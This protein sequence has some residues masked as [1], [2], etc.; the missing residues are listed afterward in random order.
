MQTVAAR[1]GI[2]GVGLGKV[3][4][5]HRIPVPGRGYWQQVRAGHRRKQK[6]LPPLNG[7][8]KADTVV[9]TPRTPSARRTQESALPVMQVE[10]SQELVAPHREVEKALRSLRGARKGE[11]GVLVPRA[12]RRLDI[13]VTAGCL[14][15]A[16][17]IM[18]AV[19]KAAETLGHRVAIT[20]EPPQ[21]ACLQ[22]NGEEI[23]F[24]LQE[25]LER[26]A[27]RSTPDDRF[28]AIAQ[29]WF[30]PPK[31]DYVPTGR[32]QL[33]IESSDGGR[34]RWSDGKRR[35]LEDHLGHFLRGLTLAAEARV[36]GRARAA[37]YEQRRREETERRIE[38]DRRRWEEKRREEALLRQ[39]RDWITAR[40]VRLYLIELRKAARVMVP[41]NLGVDSA[42]SWISWA[43][44][45]AQRLDPV[46][47]ARR[48]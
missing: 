18:D 33:K 25:Q 5:R 30:Q 44:S 26:V 2:S 29:S 46:S 6:E 22:V 36:A 42:E 28:K 3:C 40:D 20:A 24:S 1:Y 35:T 21:R 19:L 17:R 41:S 27:H 13:R 14:D 38:A 12:A 32:L 34:N 11:W 15:R 43:A 45:Y 4:R 9:L 10:V 16:L 31:F 23:R 47:Q 39:V 7:K 8:E 37:E 48:G